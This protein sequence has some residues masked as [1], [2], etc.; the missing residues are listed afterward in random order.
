MWVSDGVAAP[1]WTPVSPVSGE[2][3]ACQWKTP[4]DMPEDLEADQI[5]AAATAPAA[6]PQIAAA[7][8]RETPVDGV[9]SPRPPDDPG[10]SDD[11]PDLQPRRA[12]G[13]G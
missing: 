2:I 8:P 5:S 11:D 7:P 12:F 1:R 3:V 13:E 9:V 4:Y 10:L 6:T